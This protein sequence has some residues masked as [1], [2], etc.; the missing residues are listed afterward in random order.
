M[1]APILASWL[2]PLSMGLCGA[3]IPALQGNLHDHSHDVACI[4]SS[5]FGKAFALTSYGLLLLIPLILI[6]PI[7]IYIIV[8]VKKSGRIFVRSNNNPNQ[9]ASVNNRISVRDNPQRRR[10]MKLTKGIILIL[11]ANLICLSPIIILDFFHT[12]LGLPIPYP[13]EELG[14]L[15][16]HLNAVLDPPIYMGHSKDVTR[17]VARLCCQL[18]G[19]DEA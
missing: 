14:L 15:I 17:A 11:G 16:L 7:Y 4:H 10:E 13:L 6:F 8:Q 2:I 18:Y 5:T 9:P 12:I 3:F 19:N 1:I